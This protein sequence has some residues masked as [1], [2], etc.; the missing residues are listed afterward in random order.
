LPA[1]VAVYSD[2][3]QK[4]FIAAIPM[5]G[6]AFVSCLFLEWRSVTDKK[7]LA[8]EEAYKKLQARKETEQAIIEAHRRS[9]SRTLTGFSMSSAGWKAG[10]DC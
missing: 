1:L 2:A 9:D 3:L 8:D 6:L 10:S 7:R 5:I 4:V